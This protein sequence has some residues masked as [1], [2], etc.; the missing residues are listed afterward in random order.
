[1]S[2]QQREKLGAESKSKTDRGERSR[3]M[4][5]SARAP[6]YRSKS[7]LL[8]WLN[9]LSTWMTLPRH[10]GRSPRFE[11]QVYEGDSRVTVKGTAVSPCHR[12]DH[13]RFA[14]KA[15]AV[16]GNVIRLLTTLTSLVAEA[17]VL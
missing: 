4:T 16:Q 10:K 12:E 3:S 14:L 2:A 9:E 11:V 15:Y 7:G 13:S 6:K 5:A 17:S 8:G 1:M